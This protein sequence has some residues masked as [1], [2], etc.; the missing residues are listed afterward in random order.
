M[1]IE[2]NMELDYLASTVHIQI[3]D[4]GCAYLDERWSGKNIRS[5][6]SRLYYILGG[7]GTIETV[8]EQGTSLQTVRLVPENLCLIP[9]GMLHHYSCSSH[10]EK[11]YFHVNVT[12]PSG[13]DLLS[14]YPSCCIL[15]C[16]AGRAQQMRS[17]Y[18]SQGILSVLHI[19]SELVRDV[20]QLVQKMQPNAFPSPTYSRLLQR[21]FSMAASP[22]NAKNNVRS[23]A[24]RLNVS[25]STLAKKFKAQTGETLG[26]YLDELLLK[27]C[28]QMLLASSL[29]LRDISD[30][31]GFTDQF[32]FSRYFK[33]HMGEPPSIYRRR[34][35]KSMGRE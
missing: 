26:S 11:V 6:F 25:E 19:Q 23:L 32:Y 20:C 2:K 14:G 15:P 9:A 12:L 4:S 29:S 31:L 34:M 16:P 33:Q 10:L 17:L 8:S 3:V 13:L 21:L 5:P 7:S 28:C 18:E 1:R 30:E 35:L 22:V 27:Q 24:K